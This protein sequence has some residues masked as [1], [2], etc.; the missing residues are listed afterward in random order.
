MQKE[1][2]EA[3]LELSECE[4]VSV[5]Y[6]NIPSLSKR[7]STDHTSVTRKNRLRLCAVYNRLRGRTPG[8]RLGDFRVLLRFSNFLII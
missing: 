2:R 3:Q 7:K 5:S 1:E 6:D 4:R 8:T